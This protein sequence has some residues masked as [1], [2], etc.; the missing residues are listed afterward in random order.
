[1]S[2]KE[3]Y[4]KLVISD[5]EYSIYLINQDKTT[6]LNKKNTLIM[7]KILKKY[8]YKQTNNNTYIFPNIAPIMISFEKEIIKIKRKKV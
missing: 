5:N 2:K 6:K 4:I 3:Q 1:M 8:I 7:S